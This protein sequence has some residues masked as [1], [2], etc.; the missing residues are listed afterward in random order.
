MG[1]TTG[2]CLSVLGDSTTIL[3]RESVRRLE[4][5]AWPGEANV[6]GLARTELGYLRPWTLYPDFTSNGEGREGGLTWLQ[7]LPSSLSGIHSSGSSVLSET[8]WRIR[9]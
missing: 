7:E 6:H 4:A 1:S 2:E 9:V 5:E 3:T 8:S